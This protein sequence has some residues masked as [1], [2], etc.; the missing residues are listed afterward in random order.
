[1]IR[2]KRFR[3]STGM[4]KK[5]LAEKVKDHW[6]LMVIKG[7]FDFL[8]MNNHN[9]IE[10]IKYASKYLVFVS[11]RKSDKAVSAAKPIITRFVFFLNKKKL[12]RLDE[13]SVTVIDNFID[14]L[15]SQDLS[16]KSVKNFIGEI[17]LMFNQA[18]KEGLITIN[19]TKMAT[20]PRIE[21]TIKHRHLESTDL[22]IIFKAPCEWTYYFQFL[23]YTG[24]RAGDVAMLTFDN[25]N[26]KN[27]TII[28]YIRKSRQ[29]HEIPL[30][31]TLF[32]Q[33][34]INRIGPYP[35]FPE[36]YAKSERTLNYNLSKPRKYLQYLLRLYGRPKATLHSFRVTFNNT[37]R[38]LGLS[39][40]DRRILLAHSST[41]TTK[42]YTHPN[43]QLAREY[44]NKLPKYGIDPT[45]QEPN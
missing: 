41:E 39:I 23:L 18:I 4:T 10:V 6:D 25:I 20:L 31:D 40:E 43:I 22:K 44:I 32:N 33:L 9:P 36:V 1:M 15:Q 30:N 28:G 37:L 8:N 26:V 2:G 35:I 27:R 11:K 24:L 12:N 34:Q 7:Q 29:L 16:P 17:S 5:H 13:I 21:K 14:H 45:D 42:I 19:P 38:D 3:K